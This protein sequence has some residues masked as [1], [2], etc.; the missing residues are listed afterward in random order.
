MIVPTFLVVITTALYIPIATAA[1]QAQVKRTY[2]PSSS[3]SNGHGGRGHVS[4][5][6]ESLDIVIDKLELGGLTIPSV[7]STVMNTK[8]GAKNFGNVAESTSGASVSRGHGYDG[9]DSVGEQVV[10]YGAGGISSA[11]Q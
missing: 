6:P 4:G 5:W 1:T 7:Q 10:D 2:G 9:G 3:S 8:I 11:R